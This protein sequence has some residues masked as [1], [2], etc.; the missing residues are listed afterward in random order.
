MKMWK[1]AY[2]IGNELIDDQHREL[3]RMSDD[4]VDAIRQDGEAG[5]DACAR[6]VTFLKD[7]VVK[8]FADE[9]ALQADLGYEGLARHKK[10][11][12]DFIE[13]VLDYERRLTESDF[14]AKLM[15]RFAGKLV[16]WLIYHI[17][18]EDRKITGMIVS[19]A[20]QTA[21]PVIP[22]RLISCFADSACEVLN[23][24]LNIPFVVADDEPD[25][26]DINDI[27]AR[28]GLVGDR[29]GAAEFVFPLVTALRIVQNMTM[30]D[31]NDFD[32][33]MESALR[34][35]ANI[36]SGN[37]ASKIA[38]TGCVCD[39]TPP[40]LY[41]GRPPLLGG[42]KRVRCELGAITILFHDAVPAP[43]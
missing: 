35:I 33:M 24:M 14:D 32:E 4:L 26:G 13:E 6:A 15:Q 40:K 18:G 38:E 41:R 22:E 29:P 28:V 20:P 34:E 39:I 25:G 19:R 42:G 31:P 37:A 16:G 1:D 9:E 27:C 43:K 21:R 2:A 11:H 30:V 23:Q 36:I 12:G 3:F 5:R 8:H 17:M 7:Y 10:L